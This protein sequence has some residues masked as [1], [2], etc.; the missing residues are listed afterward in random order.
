[1]TKVSE[2]TADGNTV[3][4]Y[5][6]GESVIPTFQKMVKTDDGKEVMKTYF[7]PV[8]TISGEI[9][10]TPLDKIPNPHT[11]KVLIYKDLDILVA[12]QRG[13]RQLGIRT[14]DIIAVDAAST[15]S[16]GGGPFGNGA[17]AEEGM[18]RGSDLY[19][20]LGLEQ[21]DPFYNN[22]FSEKIAIPNPTVSDMEK[23]Y[24]NPYEVLIVKHG[25]I[26]R[27]ATTG[28]VHAQSDTTI[29]NAPRIN[30]LARAS[31]NLNPG[32]GTDYLPYLPFEDAYQTVDVT[33]PGGRTAKTTIIN[34]K[35]KD[36]IGKLVKK[37]IPEQTD[38]MVLAA[39][40]SG[41]K[42]LCVNNLGGGVFCNGVTA[43]AEAFAN[44]IKKY[45][46]NLS[47]IFTIYD[48]DRKGNVITLGSNSRIEDLI[49]SETPE[50]RGK[51]NSQIYFDAM[52]EQGLNVQW[53]E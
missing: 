1:M 42:A 53:V 44:S 29:A 51:L 50:A 10:H 46:G 38:Q 24:F 6:E 22:P 4:S 12:A 31:R 45:G 25:H 11:G 33:K 18:C 35:L 15:K 43:Y 27:D 28:M 39:I 41:C 26:F 48:K 40:K 30:Y 23:F 16:P 32:V 14:E 36:R 2:K 47:V 8:S 19:L 52:V 34:P 7:S 17:A 13:A 21:M 37:E 9:I 49:P 20:C 3:T 5:V